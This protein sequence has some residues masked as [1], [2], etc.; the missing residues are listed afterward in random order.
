MKIKEKKKILFNITQP[1]CLEDPSS[2]GDSPVKG[3]SSL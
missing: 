3:Q 1:D 2:L